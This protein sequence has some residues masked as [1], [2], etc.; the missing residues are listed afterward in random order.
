MLLYNFAKYLPF[1]P[2]IS[3]L[4][5]TSLFPGKLIYRYYFRRV[6]MSSYS[7]GF[8]QQMTSVRYQKMRREGG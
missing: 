2:L 7:I 1:D 3:T 5:S 4:F 6:L 8:G